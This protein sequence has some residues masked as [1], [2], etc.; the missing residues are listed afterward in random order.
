MCIRDSDEPCLERIAY[1]LDDTT[2]TRAVF[3][4]NKGVNQFDHYSVNDSIAEN[5]RRVPI[6]QMVY[7]ADGPSDVPV[8]SIVKRYGGQTYGV[9]DPDVKGSYD[10][11]FKLHRQ[12]RLSQYG[13]A[14]Y[15]VGGETANWIEA[16]VRDVADGIIKSQEFKL[17]ESFGT[18]PGHE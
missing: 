5:E 17:D 4:I 15:R 10:K 12:K 11:V 13:T 3:E 6:N 18:A 9:Y 1:V 2:K 14:D 7:I 16:A 8:F